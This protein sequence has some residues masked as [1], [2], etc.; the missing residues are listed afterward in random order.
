MKA[1]GGL[2]LLSFL[3]AVYGCG[4][5]FTC[6]A[7]AGGM[8]CSSVSTVYEKALSGEIAAGISQKTK[9]PA[10]DEEPSEVKK[11]TI[12]AK[13]ETDKMIPLRT[14]PRIIRMWFSPWEDDDGDLNQGGYV[15]SEITDPKNRWI[16]GEKNQKDRI[17]DAVKFFSGKMPLKQREGVVE[18]DRLMSDKQPSPAAQ[19]PQAQKARPAQP[20]A[21]ALPRKQAPEMT[22]GKPVLTEPDG[23]DDACKN[24]SCVIGE[25][26]KKQK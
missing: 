16:I 15:Y 24:S 6:P 26:T 19:P 23:V 21:A 22:S 25:K 12:S 10:P 4:A 1:L 11:P 2:L 14:P 5:T 7:P 9:S 20:A 18:K 3:F 17:G 8:K 13:L